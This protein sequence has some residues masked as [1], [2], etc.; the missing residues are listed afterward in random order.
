MT[1]GMD[2]TGLI[3]SG[4]AIRIHEI[5]YMQNLRGHRADRGMCLVVF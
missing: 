5:D 4:D 2:G 1:S 3:P